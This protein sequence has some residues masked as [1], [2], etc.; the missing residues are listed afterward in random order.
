MPTSVSVIA[1]APALKLT[2]PAPAV[3]V[4]A[5]DCVMPAP[6]TA[7]VPVPSDVAPIVTAPVADSVSAPVP[8]SASEFPDVSIVLFD[9]RV[10]LRF[11][12]SA[13]GLLSR[14]TGPANA[15]PTVRLE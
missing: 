5:P 2:L 6:V 15:E 7:I 13:T 1:L 8:D 11:A 9:S 14:L 12:P 4:T 10:R 3:W